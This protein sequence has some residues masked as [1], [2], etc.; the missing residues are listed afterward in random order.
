LTQTP[1]KTILRFFKKKKNEREREVNYLFIIYYL[2][3]K[4]GISFNRGK[5]QEGCV[6]D[7]RLLIRL[8]E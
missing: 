8:F 6:R 5:G 3:K 2:L 7:D 1:I 4:K